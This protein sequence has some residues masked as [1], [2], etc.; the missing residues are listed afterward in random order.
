MVK[1]FTHTYTPEKLGALEREKLR[2]I[3]E[4]ALRLGADDLVRN[5]D[6]ELARRAPVK[7]RRDQAS[8]RRNDD[9][10]VVGY[11]FVCSKDR[12]VIEDGNGRFRSGSWVVAE[13]NIAA[14]LAFGAYL[15]LHDAKNEPSYRQG[16]IIGYALSPRDMIDKDNIGIEFLVQETG[17][18]YQWV[19]GGSGEK[20]YNWRSAKP[21]ES[22]DG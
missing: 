22:D 19:G 20:G 18:H 5:C 14:S 6:D 21:S 1:K 3:R 8:S 7:Q 12:G 16:Q 13:S 9:D 4:N 10:V 11:H 17:S 2:T 15:A